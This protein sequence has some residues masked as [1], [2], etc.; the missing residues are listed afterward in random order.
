[1]PVLPYRMIARRNTTAGWAASV[2]PTLTGELLY[3]TTAGTAKIGNGGLYSSIPDSFAQVKYLNGYASVAAAI[4]AIGST[5]TRLVV[6]TTHNITADT[7][8]NPNT[9]IEREAGGIFNV[10]ATKTL[11]AYNVINPTGELM[12]TGSGTARVYQPEI[13]A[14][15]WAGKETDDT[16]TAAMWSAMQLSMTAIGGGTIK[17]SSVEQ[18]TD[19]EITVPDGTRIDGGG[20]TPNVTGTILKPNEDAK[21]VFRILGNS[22]NCALSNLVIDNTAMTDATGLEFYGTAPNS[23]I[24]AKV[25]NVTFN[26]G[27]RGMAKN[28]TDN[29]WQV[30]GVYVNNCY[31]MY[32]TDECYYVN[33]INGSITFDTCHF[34]PDQNGTAAVFRGPYSTSINCYNCNYYGATVSPSAYHETISSYNDATGEWTATASHHLPASPEP[35]PVQLVVTGGA[36]PTTFAV[37]TV[38]YARKTGAAT[39]K[40]YDNALYAHD[41]SVPLVGGGSGSGT[42]QLRTMIP[43]TAGRPLTVF[44]IQGP[45]PGINVFGGQS[46]GFPYFALLSGVNDR[47]AMFRLFGVT[48]QGAIKVTSNCTVETYGCHHYAKTFQ[49]VWGTL[50]EFRSYGDVVQY[51]AGFGNH[52]IGQTDSP[53]VLSAFS[54]SSFLRRADT[55]RGLEMQDL[56]E[57]S[58]NYLYDATYSPITTVRND[59]G[60]PLMR[61]SVADARGRPTYSY[62]F[63]RQG[64][65]LKAGALVLDSNRIGV[66]AARYIGLDTQSSLFFAGRIA[67]EQVTTLTSATTVEIDMLLGS[68]FRIA[69]GH[70]IDFEIAAHA[71]ALEGQDLWLLIQVLDST[72]RTHTFNAASQFRAKGNLVTGA[73]NGSYFLHFQN[74]G[75]YF[76]EQGERAFVP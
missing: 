55:S 23:V 71:D 50:C 14:G 61:M 60:K 11:I 38:Y 63:L 68:R 40:L 13:H 19:V 9:V 39:F 36:L 53:E 15:W 46:E 73:T 28:S 34:Y 75:G 20:G 2:T 7:T 8:F 1:M 45:H 43:I 62:E 49:D 65:G 32:Q 5:P 42:M 27:K 6:K 30:E 12:F 18:F 16:I 21:A 37:K 29:G 17:L 26:R 48:T 25:E 70:D 56:M 69:H 4:T 76:I 41:D 66:D 52:D 57:V 54:G 31:F 67:N 33:T 10:S 22:R 74:W 3:D 35:T 47:G 72:S 59:N 64:T 24:G 58:L 51:F 44:D